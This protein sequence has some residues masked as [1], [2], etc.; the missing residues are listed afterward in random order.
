MKIRPAGQ[1]G[2][3]AAETGLPYAKR[4]YYTSSTH[5]MN[6]LHLHLP[7][8]PLDVA[9][10]EERSPLQ[11]YP[12]L[13]VVSVLV[14]KEI[15]IGILEPQISHHPRDLF[16]CACASFLLAQTRQLRPHRL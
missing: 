4:M 5:V 1:D 9:M 13:C 14:R 6:D 12:Q 16:R 7:L 3:K 15:S 2:K 11:L 10:V 8:S